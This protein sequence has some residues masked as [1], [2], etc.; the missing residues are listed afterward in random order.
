MPSRREFLDQ[1]RAAPVRRDWAGARDLDPLIR[2]VQRVWSPEN[3]WHIGDIAWDIGRH[4]DGRPDWRM[5]LWERDGRIAAWGWLQLPAELALVV[6]PDDADLVDA[7][8]D[9]AD[10]TAGV[11]VAVTVLSTE[12]W[13]IAPLVR[14]GYAADTSGPFF[15]AHHRGLA[16]LPPVPPLPDGFTVRP[17]TGADEIPARAAL[18][19]A[20]WSAGSLPDDVFTAMTGRY[21]YRAGFDHV[22]RAPDGRLVAYVLGWFDEVNAC[23]EFEPVGT[24]APYRRMGLSRALGISVLRAFRDAGARTALVYARGDDDYPVPRQVYGALGFRPRG[25]TVTYRPP[26]AR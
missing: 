6:G 26:A 3:R 1:R 14:R 18:D 22:A 20:V 12:T 2:F 23:G 24:L 10:A 11:R 8:V 7:V 17:T 5:A 19:R 25:R 9:W 16:D 4:P 13:Q 21:P 15:L